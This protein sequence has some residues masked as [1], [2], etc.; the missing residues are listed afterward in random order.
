MTETGVVSGTLETADSGILLTGIPAYK[1]FQVVLDGEKVSYTSI[2]GALIGI[3][4]EAGEH[5][6][7]IEYHI[8]YM[9][10]ALLGTI[11]GIIIFVLCVFMGN[12]K[13][14]VIEKSE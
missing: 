11:L 7:V 5:T 9:K 8:P 13:Q 12:G 2:G 4:V 6:I 1:G 14:S 3:P 10:L